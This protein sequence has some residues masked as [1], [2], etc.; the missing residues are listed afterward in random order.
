MDAFSERHLT[1]LLK[2]ILHFFLKNSI[3]FW[4]ENLS[5]FLNFSKNTSVRVQ[6]LQLPSS[7]SIENLANARNQSLSA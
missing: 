1:P 7:M 6:F 5:L 4:I 2:I 3:N